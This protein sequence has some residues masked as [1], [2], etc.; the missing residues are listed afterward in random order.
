MMYCCS[1]ADGR[2][3]TFPYLRFCVPLFQSWSSEKERQLLAGS[4]TSVAF[5]QK[6]PR[7][8][9]LIRALAFG[10]LGSL[11]W[12][13]RF[14]WSGLGAPSLTRSHLCM[15]EVLP[16]SSFQLSCLHV[17][18]CRAKFKSEELLRTNTIRLLGNEL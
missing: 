6:G 11:A 15:F 14:G 13:V 9:S 12:W 5:I 7:E 4:G 1:I 10:I 17:C 3:V 16:T 8:H 18:F 2:D